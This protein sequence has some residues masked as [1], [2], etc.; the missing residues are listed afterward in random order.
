LCVELKI[1]F[2]VYYGVA[3]VM[4]WALLRVTDN[5]VCLL[6]NPWISRFIFMFVID[7]QDWAS[8]NDELLNIILDAQL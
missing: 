3:L 1:A 4:R 5:L 7:V 2:N 6:I 8:S